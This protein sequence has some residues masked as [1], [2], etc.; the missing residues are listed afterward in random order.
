MDKDVY[1]KFL[2]LTMLLTVT[3]CVGIGGNS[4][5]THHYVLSSAAAVDATTDYQSEE[6]SIGLWLVTLPDILDR[7]QIVTRI[8]QYGVQL[9]EFDR[10]AGD[11]KL[12]MTH[13]IADELRIRLRTGRVSVY[14]WLTNQTIN[15][16]VKVDVTR[17][18]GTLGGT[19]VLKGTWILLDGGGKKELLHEAFLINANAKDSSY[20]AM[21]AA[22]SKLVT[23]LSEQ[24]SV[25][26]A[27]Q[28]KSLH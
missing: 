2:I 25:G 23:S 13:H 3:A 21:V 14:P 24:I 6:L 12:N 1:K 10:W 7:P 19:T 28:K 4:P 8:D 27:K 22:L 9:G 20:T 18:D 16:Q 17:F 11:L 26:I 15:Y 5:P